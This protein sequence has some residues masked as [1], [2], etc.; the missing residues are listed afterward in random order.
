MDFQNYEEHKVKTDETIASVAKDAGMSW[1]ELALFNWG[2]SKPRK[3]NAALHEFVGCKKLTKNGR[4]YMFTTADNPGIVFIPRPSP[5]FDL[6]TD[7]HHKITVKLARM[8]TRVQIQTVDELGHRLPHIDLVLQS[9]EGLPD[10]PITTDDL[11]HAKKE[12][13]RA[14]KYKIVLKDGTPVYYRWNLVNAQNQNGQ[15]VF[16]EFVEA[17][18][19]TK[20]FTRSLTTVVVRGT[21]TKEQQNEVALVRQQNLRTG[22]SYSIKGRSQQESKEQGVTVRSR[23]LAIDN[24]AIAAGWSDDFDEIKVKDLVSDIL[25]GWLKDYHSTATRNGYFVVMLR[26]E[27]KRIE[28]WSSSGSKESSFGLRVGYEP[29]GLIGA[30]TVFE[31]IGDNRFRDMTYRSAVI[32]PGDQMADS[33][34]SSGS[35][36]TGED[37]HQLSSMVQLNELVDDAEGLV[38]AYNRHP[39]ELMVLYY[40]PS[41]GTLAWAA[42]YGGVGYLEDYGNSADVNQS[43]HARNLK[44]CANITRAYKAYVQWYGK[45]IQPMSKKELKDFGPPRAPYQMPAPANSTFD[46][47]VN[48]LSVQRSDEFHAWKAVADK[49]NELYHYPNEGT[50]FLRIKGKTGLNVSKLY[51]KYKDWL[52]P[53]WP[54]ASDKVF[55]IDYEIEGSLEIRQI[56]QHWHAITGSKQY[57]KANLKFEPGIPAS[58]LGDLPDPKGV[59]QEGNLK[60]FKLEFGLKS[61]LDDPRRW[62]FSTTIGPFKSELGS[63]AELKLQYEMIPDT[64]SVMSA[65]S[66]VDAEFS[67]GFVLSF[68]GLAKALKGRGAPEGSNKSDYDVFLE[69]LEKTEIETSFG[70]TGVYEETVLAVIISA[71]GFF[72]RRDID[73][74]F[75]PNLQWNDLKSD[76]QVQLHELGWMLRSWDGKYYLPESDLPD[77]WNKTIFQLTAPEKVAIVNLG[78]RRYE[79]YGKR[80]KAERKKHVSEKPGLFFLPM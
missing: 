29:S 40:L 4:N 50:P 53:G 36:A 23:V 67:A 64:F 22:K 79:D 76:E 41:A 19:D 46:Q 78:F 39:G 21:L 2:T 30:Y 55:P 52:R 71:P 15:V 48:L 70:F 42:V 10:V 3:I 13:V 31:D 8:L 33:R 62:K 37:E 56:G 6:P 20:N 45:Q 75:D 5:E 63:R 58:W 49:I 12:K 16:G 28:V 14:G 57:V 66:E 47:R 24:L 7:A 77:S 32:D 35:A 73:E 34:D 43:A 51:N 1:Q 25:G 59:G 69:A 60:K 18:L 74:L 17:E 61:D 11:G 9:K 44:V 68:K 27:E 54:Q 80:F 65:A 72:E 26:P 38:A